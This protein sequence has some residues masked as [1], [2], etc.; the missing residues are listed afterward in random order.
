MNQ[1][2]Y[3]LIVIVILGVALQLVS[4]GLQKLLMR[5]FGLNA[6]YYLFGIVGTAVHELSHVAMCVLF[7]HRIVGL[8]LFSLRPN[9]SEWGRVSHVWDKGSFYQSAGNFFIGAAPLIGGIFVPMLL[10]LW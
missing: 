6:Y 8:K 5:V 1:V 10:A 9:K 3:G 4:L 2:I 7:R